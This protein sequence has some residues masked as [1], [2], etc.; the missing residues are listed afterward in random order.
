[1]GADYEDEAIADLNVIRSARYSGF[2]TE[3]PALTGNALKNLI[4]DERRRELAFEG[5]RFF[6]LKRKGLPIGRSA[7]GDEA[8]GEGNPVP[9]DLRTMEA[10]ST[11]F[12]LPIPQDELNANKNMKQNPGY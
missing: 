1:M 4:L 8:G 6:D 11:M 7:F 9:E 10:Q 3:T 12:Q 2:V 5:H